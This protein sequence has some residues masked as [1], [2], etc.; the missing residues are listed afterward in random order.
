M[1]KLNCFEKF[2]IFVKLAGDD[3]LYDKILIPKLQSASEELGGNL[4]GAYDDDIESLP[5]VKSAL[6]DSSKQ[7]LFVFDDMNEESSQNLKRIDE[8]FTKARKRN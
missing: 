8:Y 2:Y 4:V 1:H 5:D 6:M 3:N 7:N